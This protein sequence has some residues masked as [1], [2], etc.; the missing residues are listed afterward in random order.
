MNGVGVAAGVLTSFAI[1]M[2]VVADFV[3]AN[4]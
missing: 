2:T 1:V 4:L 3:G